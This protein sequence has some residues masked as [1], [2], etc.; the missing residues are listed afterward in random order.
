MSPLALLWQLVIVGQVDGV[1]VPDRS[2]L[3]VSGA[4]PVTVTLSLAGDAVPGALYSWQGTTPSALLPTGTGTEFSVTVEQPGP[5]HISVARVNPATGEVQQGRF[6]FARG[7][8]YTASEWAPAISVDTGGILVAVLDTGLNPLHPVLRGRIAAVGRDFVEEDDDPADDMGHGT[9]IAGI[10]AEGA[11]A[12]RILPVKV[13]HAFGLGYITTVLA[14]V[15]YALS[16]GARILV[17]ASGTDDSA[18]AEVYGTILRE[19]ADA[20]ALVVTT[21]GNRPDPVDLDTHPYFPAVLRLGPMLVVSAVDVH[22]NRAPYS[23]YGAATVDVAAYGGAGT[24]EDPGPLCA[25]FR[26]R[27]E[28]LRHAMRGTSFAA[29]VVAAVAARIW[30]ADSTLS[31][32]EVRSRVRAAA[33]NGIL[34]FSNL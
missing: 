27:G 6:A 14:G 29:P 4:G 16:R 34:S 12:A 15:R 2:E 19:A 24:A 10:I 23:N 21:A 26:S 31:A 22:G 11:P 30:A 9:A 28:D 5:V 3:A 20:G 33:V 13:S 25:D 7:A 32:E 17:L 18:S 8:M 1:A